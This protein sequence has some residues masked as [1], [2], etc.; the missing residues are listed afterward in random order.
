MHP[1][2]KTAALFGAAVLRCPGMQR[3]KGSFDEFCDFFGQEQHDLLRDFL[4]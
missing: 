4:F 1:K 2:R 3:P